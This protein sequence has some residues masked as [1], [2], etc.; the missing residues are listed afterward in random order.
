MATGGITASSGNKMIVNHIKT[1]VRNKNLAKDRGDDDRVVSMQQNDGGM[2]Q[3][4]M[5]EVAFNAKDL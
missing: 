1:I 3:M 5:T 2:T 4:N